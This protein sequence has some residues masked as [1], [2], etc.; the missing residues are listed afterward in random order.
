MTASLETRGCA[1]GYVL[2]CQPQ[3]C[4]LIGV[5]VASSPWLKIMLICI[6]CQTTH[7]TI[8]EENKIHGRICKSS[9]YVNLLY[10]YPIVTRS[11]FTFWSIECAYWSMPQQD[12]LKDPWFHP[13]YFIIYKQF[14]WT[15]IRIRRD[16]HQQSEDARMH[17]YDIGSDS[18]GSHK[19]KENKP[20]TKSL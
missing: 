18:S 4:F 2:C 20:Q 13:K 17:D 11:C 1:S 8:S 19:F 10:V 16:R 9:Q 14:D 7:G 15:C 12:S 6:I 3:A 5:G